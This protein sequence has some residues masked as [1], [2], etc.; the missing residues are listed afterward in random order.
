MKRHIQYVAPSLTDIAF[1]ADEMF[2]QYNEQYPDL[3]DP[4]IR[5]EVISFI[6][7]AGQ[8]LAKSLS[9]KEEVS[10]SVDTEGK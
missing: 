7:L 10:N 6:W 9:T 8:I 1:S 4:Q 5:Q 2:A 3:T